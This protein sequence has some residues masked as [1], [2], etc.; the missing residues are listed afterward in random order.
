MVRNIPFRHLLLKGALPVIYLQLVA[1]HLLLSLAP[2]TA[3]AA[4]YTIDPDHS[5]VTFKV[6]HLG[7]SWV[8]GKFNEF[9]GTFSFDPENL[10]ASATTASI[11]SGSIDTDNAK[12][13]GHLKTNEF[14]DTDNFKEITFTSTKVVPKTK[15]EFEVKGDL[16]IKEISKPVTLNVEY[17]GSAKGMQGEERA[18]F[19]ATTTVKR[20]DWGITW[21]KLLEAGGLAV[22]EDVFVTIEIEGIKQ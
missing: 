4:D 22:G 5:K 15:S 2:S 17:H 7:I 9:K 1:F 3:F 11:T 16:K 18:A 13:D 19:T 14:L 10:A 12:R 6:K 8:P 21:N 20:K